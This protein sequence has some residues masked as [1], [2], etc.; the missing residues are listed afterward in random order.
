MI[1]RKRNSGTVHEC[2]DAR[3]FESHR[4]ADVRLFVLGL[5]RD[6]SVDS[7]VVVGSDSIARGDVHRC[8]RCPAAANANADGDA[9]DIVC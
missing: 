8:C 7:I 4:R 5:R 6:D 9:K 3:A 2:G 1:W